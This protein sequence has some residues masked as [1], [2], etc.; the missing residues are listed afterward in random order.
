MDN[1]VLNAPKIRK[2]DDMKLPNGFGSVYKLSGKR[3]KPWCARK[4]IGWTF[5][6][7]KQKSFPV[8]VFLGYYQSRSEALL[9]LTDYN[10]SPYDLQT[11]NLTFT[12]VFERF[13]K[14]HCTKV[15]EAS[16]TEYRK[17]YKLCEPIHRM[18]FSEIKL[19][20]LQTMVDESGKNKP[21]LKKLKNLLNLMWN[22]AV[23]T[24]IITPFHVYMIIT[25]C[26]VK[27]KCFS[28]TQILHKR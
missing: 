15:S 27:P 10:R 19:H 13:L 21:T 26:R 17:A 1:G 23:M 24:E 5:D 25:G 6:E 14:Q 16:M 3:R 8:Y 28:R 12:D 4:T 7:E 2:D 22:Y 11:L 9:A 20:H 18:K